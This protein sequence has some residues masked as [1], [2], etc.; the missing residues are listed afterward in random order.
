MNFEVKGLILFIP[1]C[2]IS[3]H[4]YYIY[5]YCIELRK[6]TYAYICRFIIYTIYI[7]HNFAV[8]ICTMLFIFVLNKNRHKR[9][10]NKMHH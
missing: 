10:M 9:E 5:I 8:F 3:L 1:V 4:M 6:Y 2:T 7:S